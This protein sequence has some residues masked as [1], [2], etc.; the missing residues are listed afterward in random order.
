[1]NAVEA[2]SLRQYLKNAAEDVKGLKLLI[3]SCIFN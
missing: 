3:L 1:M 2:R